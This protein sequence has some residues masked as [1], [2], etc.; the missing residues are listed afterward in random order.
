MPLKETLATGLAF[1]I[2]GKGIATVFDRSVP[3]VVAGALADLVDFTVSESN[4][5]TFRWTRTTLAIG[6]R[7]AILAVLARTTGLIVRS[8]S[9]AMFAIRSGAARAALTTRSAVSAAR[10]TLTTRGAVRAARTTLTTRSAVRAAR[11]AGLLVG[12]ATI[13]ATRSAFSIT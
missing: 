4:G 5:A 9:S 3:T 8:T 13:G 7:A 6:A 10:A 12:G 1:G 11:T 2:R